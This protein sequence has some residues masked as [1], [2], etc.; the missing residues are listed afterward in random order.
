MSTLKSHEKVVFEK[1]FDRNGY[2]LDFTDK[3]FS[4]FFRENGVNIDADH[5]KFNGPSKMKRLRAFWE[6][7]ENPLV[8][9]VLKALLDYACAVEKVDE[10]NKAKAT[11]IICH[12]LGKSI[13]IS[14]PSSS[15]SDFLA[16]EFSKA[17]LSKLNID[18]K[19]QTVIEQ[20]ISEIH[21]SLKVDSALAVVFLCG[22][23]LEGLLLDAA[24]KNSK[25][26]NQAKSA[27]KDAAGAVKSL[28][29][30]R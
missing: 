28:R 19:F 18:A 7:E 24:S 4:E 20:R 1:L 8:G 21:K 27:P 29:I 12:L 5:Y 30:G 25:A 15:E 26:F 10:A 16:K 23:T 17:N 22:S 9:R 14:D 11:E 2:V 6:V 13:S 3:T